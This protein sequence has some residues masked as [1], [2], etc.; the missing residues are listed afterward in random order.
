MHYSLTGVT[1][2]PDSKALL[3]LQ[4][5][6]A[7]V[8]FAGTRP[9]HAALPAAYFLNSLWMAM[10]LGQVKLFYNDFGQ[11]M[12]YVAWALLTPEVERRTL[13]NGR[14]ELR[15]FE[16]NE[17]PSLWIVD[18]AIEKGALKA[19]MEN[20]RDVLFADHRVVTFARQ[21]NG[22]AVFK[23]ASRDSTSWFWRARLES[24][25]ATAAG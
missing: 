9:S 2:Q 11:C 7:L 20:M 21:R 22:R 13:R 3:S 14:L 16:W 25:K 10:S 17:G 6:G 12:G 23:R 18:F 8:H 4:T 24:S 15:D 1:G 5:L 19:S